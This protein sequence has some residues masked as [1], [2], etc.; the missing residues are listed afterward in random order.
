MRE[1]DHDDAPLVPSVQTKHQQKTFI[2][3]DADER[4]PDM[5]FDDLEIDES[6]LDMQDIMNRVSLQ[7]SEPPTQATIP[8]PRSFTKILV[9]FTDRGSL[10][11]KVARKSE[12]G[13]THH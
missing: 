5:E 13:I 6:L 3:S 4:L 12:D 11:T 8:A 7:T 9:E 10:P 1:G 2:E